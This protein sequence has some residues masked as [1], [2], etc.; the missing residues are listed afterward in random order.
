MPRKPTFGYHFLKLARFGF[1]KIE[2]Q[3]TFRFPH[4]PSF[5]SRVNYQVNGSKVLAPCLNPILVSRMKWKREGK[6]EFGHIH[7]PTGK[8]GAE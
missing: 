5:N 3:P 8:N 4:I 2:S 1:S 6:G 7:P